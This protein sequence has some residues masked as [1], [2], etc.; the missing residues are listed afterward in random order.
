MGHRTRKDRTLALT[1]D[2]HV[3]DKP[4]RYRVMVKVLDIFGNDTSHAGAVDVE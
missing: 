4:S 2:A 1:P 3:Y